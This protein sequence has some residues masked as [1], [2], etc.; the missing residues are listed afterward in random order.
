M[1][2]PSINQKIRQALQLNRAIRFVFNA[3]PKWTLVNL[4]LVSAQGVLPLLSLYIIKLVIDSVSMALTTPDP[5]TSFHQV[6]LWI[7]L[8][9]GIAILASLF[10][11]A[12]TYTLEAQSLAVSDNISKMLQRKSVDIDFVYYENP[13]FFDTLRRA[14][15]E[16]A[17]RPTR[18]VNGMTQLFQNSISLVAMV[19]LL[20]SFNWIVGFILLFAALPGLIVRLLFSHQLYHW[21]RDRTSYERKAAYINWVLTGDTH[22]KEIRSFGLGDLFIKRYSQL[23]ETLRKEKLTITKRR[24]T[25]DFAAETAATLAIFGSFAWIAYRAVYGRISIGEMVM[26]LQAFRLGLNNLRNLLGSLSGFYEDNLFLT[27]FYDFLDLEPSIRKRPNAPAIPRPIK[28]GIVFENVGFT[29]PG[30]QKKVLDGLSVSIAPGAIV[31]L[32]GENGSGKTT[33]AKLLCRLYDPQEGRI[34]IDGIDLR[35]FNP[36]DWC[37]EISVIFQDYIQYYFSAQENIWF[38]DILQPPKCE[39]IRAAAQQAGADTMIA[40]LPGGYDAMLGKSFNKGRELSI[41]QWQ[42]IALARMLFRKAQLFIL[43]E[44]THAL[45]PKSEY[46]FL[47][48]LHRL[49]Q[50]RS[51]VLI[52][53]RLSTVRMADRILVLKNGNIVEDGSHESLVKGC[54][55]YAQ[56]FERQ[57]KKIIK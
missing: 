39:S 4:I 48:K 12:A 9:A 35:Q 22:A 49:L 51:A 38:G 2:R 27:N 30:S 16:G 47:K 10:Q 52:S 45:D 19:G 11:S 43:D 1:R 36:T 28:K 6:G 25:A 8:A 13:D 46:D 15:Q 34:T 20:F 23:R 3:A 21:Q 56:L 32:V 42:K 40:E 55:K 54:G 17:Y 18:I 14:Q 33:L 26:F 57:T 5:S 44:P 41:G 7:G 29:Y 24:T 37:R 31:A 50:D 53:H